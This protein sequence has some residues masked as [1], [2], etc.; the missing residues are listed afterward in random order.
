MYEFYHILVYYCIGC[1]THYRNRHF[2]NNVT[3]GWR[4]A[5]PCRNN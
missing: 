5:A 1:P 2:F 4:T 3:T